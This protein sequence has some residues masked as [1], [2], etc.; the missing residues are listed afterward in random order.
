MIKEIVKYKNFNDETVEATVYFNFNKTEL[1][2][3]EWSVEG[4]LSAQLKEIAEKEDLKQ[5]IPVFRE[6]VS[7]AYG[8][9]D[10]DNFIKTESIREKF[11][12]SLLCDEIIWMLI[13]DKQNASEF[14]NKLL[15]PLQDALDSKVKEST[16]DEFKKKKKKNK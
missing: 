11:K 16:L 7:R 13:S 14:V 4:G 15:Q 9:R 12:Y 2:E 8:E 6:I 1:A 3:L 5:M 10:G